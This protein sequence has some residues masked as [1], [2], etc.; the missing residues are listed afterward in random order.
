MNEDENI[1]IEAH[2]CAGAKGVRMEWDAV[3]QTDLN[4]YMIFACAQGEDELLDE[5]LQRTTSNIWAESFAAAMSQNHWHVAK[6][7]E[8][9]LAHTNELGAISK[10]FSNI[11]NSA[12]RRND[13]N[14]LQQMEKYDPTLLNYKEASLCA[15]RGIKPQC[16]NWAL[17]GWK[18]KAPVGDRFLNTVFCDAVRQRN[19]AMIK[20]VFAFLTNEEIEMWVQKSATDPNM[21]GPVAHAVLEKSVLEWHVKDIAASNTK[22]KM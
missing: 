17:N 19:A 13:M 10:V 6:R 18:T 14:V 16:L 5:L 4:D 9:H 12:C 11:W 20:T 2:I 8:E 1:L 21:F 15:V 3:A 7:I 22:R